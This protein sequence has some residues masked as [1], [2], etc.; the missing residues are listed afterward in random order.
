VLLEN[1]P[2]NIFGPDTIPQLNKIIVALETD[3]EV[4]V[5]V[6]ESTV[7]GFFLTH[8]DFTRSLEESTSLAPGPTG[9]HLL[10]DM[11]ARLTRAP[12]VS[13][14]PATCAS[15]VGKRP[16]CRNGRWARALFPVVGR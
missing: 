12:V 8:Y 2:F 1:P 7:P 5:V 14:W 15:P 9:M 16:S 3:P 13:R 4:K 10:P 11:L 6:F